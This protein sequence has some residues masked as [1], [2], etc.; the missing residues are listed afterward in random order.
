MDLGAHAGFIVS[1]YAAMGVIMGGLIAWLVRDGLR[2][3]RALRE[4]EARGVMRRSPRAD[5]TQT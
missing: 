3:A 2:Q 5:D 4:L 1:A